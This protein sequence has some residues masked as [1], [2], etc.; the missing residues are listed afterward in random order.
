[1]IYSPAKCLKKIPLEIL[2]LD[3][4]RRLKYWY[5]DKDTGEAVI[6]YIPESELKE[7]VDKWK[8]LRRCSIRVYDP[9]N[10]INLSKNDLEALHVN[11]ILHDREDR[12][13]AA[14]FRKVVDICI[15]KGI[16]VGGT[17]PAD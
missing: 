17:F 2:P 6:E 10:L 8:G 12:V 1:M 11:K 3:F 13:D 9:I 5:H 16:H 14:K 7:S 4:L 15:L